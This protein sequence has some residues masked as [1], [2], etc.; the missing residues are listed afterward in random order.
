MYTEETRCDK[1]ILV[2]N[3]KGLVLKPATVSI[4]NNV[5]HV[6]NSFIAAVARNNCPKCYKGSLSP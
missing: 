5:M 1:L 2:E 6:T 4:V 3:Q